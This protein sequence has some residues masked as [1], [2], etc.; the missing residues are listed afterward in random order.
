M[1]GEAQTATDHL[2][3]STE[4]QKECKHAKEQQKK[5]TKKTIKDISISNNCE[6]IWANEL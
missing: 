4:V 5:Q 2:S 1:G 3:V 6:L